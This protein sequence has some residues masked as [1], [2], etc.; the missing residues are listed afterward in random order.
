MKE[1]TEVWRP[2]KAAFRRS[3]QTKALLTK[4]EQRCRLHL[5]AQVP[6]IHVHVIWDSESLMNEYLMM[7]KQA[8]ILLSL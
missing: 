5:L 6:L 1:F 7:S 8:A 4:A 2:L 3:R